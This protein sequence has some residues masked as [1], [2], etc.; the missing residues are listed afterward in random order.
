MKKQILT[1]ALLA[2]GL[3]GFAQT[4][5]GHYKQVTTD[6]YKDN[7]KTATSTKFKS[8]E[9]IISADQIKIDDESYTIIKR[10]AA[11]LEDENYFT[12]AMIIL[13]KSK[14]GTYKAMDC[15][16]GLKPDKKTVYYV[17]LK[18][19]KSTKVGYELVN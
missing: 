9:F 1:I 17:L 2:A 14:T 18:K 5:N 3:S 12:Q 7:N 4:Y 10:D 16:I 11:E 13:T 19:T 8:G 6:H 15:I